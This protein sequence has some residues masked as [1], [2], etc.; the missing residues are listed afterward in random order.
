MI[1]DGLLVP[2]DKA[3]SI[4]QASSRFGVSVST[5]FRAYYL[6]VHHSFCNFMVA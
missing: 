3:P 2:G 5:V 4:R 1:S 6:V